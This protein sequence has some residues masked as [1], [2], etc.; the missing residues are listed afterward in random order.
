MTNLL[1][2]VKKHH[3]APDSQQGEAGEHKHGHV[4][5]HGA[6]YLSVA[7][8]HALSSPPAQHHAPAPH[9]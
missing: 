2:E 3:P 7:A 1:C 6:G 9:G 4:D 5:K 8:R